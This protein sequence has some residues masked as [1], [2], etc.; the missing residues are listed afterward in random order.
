[1]P[2][3][4]ATYDRQ[5]YP[6]DHPSV[7]GAFEPVE[8]TRSII[9]SGFDNRVGFPYRQWGD[10]TREWKVNGKWTEDPS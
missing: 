4:G 3:F 1:M 7:S 5:A 8:P 9:C 10:G 6:D 2:S